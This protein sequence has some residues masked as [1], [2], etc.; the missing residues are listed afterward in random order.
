MGNVLADYDDAGGVVVG[1]QLRLGQPGSVRNLAGS[2]MT[3]GYTPFDSTST[4]NFSTNWL[5]SPI[6]AIR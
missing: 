4:T 2:W 5:T 1:A 6:L 3:G